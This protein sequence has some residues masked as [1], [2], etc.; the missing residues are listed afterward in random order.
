MDNEDSVVSKSRADENLAN[1]V[2]SQRWKEYNPMLR[3]KHQ[4]V[5]I[6]FEKSDIAAQPVQ[7]I[8]SCKKDELLRSIEILLSQ[9]TISQRQNLQTKR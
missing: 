4:F 7:E 2:N 6:A 8:Q 1:E 3:K 9:K 5:Q